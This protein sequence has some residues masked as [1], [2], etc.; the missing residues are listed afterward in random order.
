M[1]RDEL[2]ATEFSKT[3]GPYVKSLPASSSP[4]NPFFSR[5]LL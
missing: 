4:L 1:P 3:L 2:Q 5:C